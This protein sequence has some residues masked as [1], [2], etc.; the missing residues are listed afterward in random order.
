MEF[1]SLFHSNKWEE[2]VGHDTLK[3]INILKLSGLFHSFQCIEI[4]GRSLIL[5]SEM[6][7]NK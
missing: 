2:E 1:F 5:T 4:L 7:T 6:P 3:G